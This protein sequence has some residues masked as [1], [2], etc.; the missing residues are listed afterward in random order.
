MRY[1]IWIVLPSVM[2][3]GCVKTSAVTEAADGVRDRVTPAA[4]GIAAGSR[5]LVRAAGQAA[6]D[7][8][9]AARVNGVLEIRR[10]LETQGIKVSAQ[11]GVVTLAGRVSSQAQKRVAG[12]VAG[13][14][15]GVRRVVNR[16]KVG[17]RG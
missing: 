9:L 6:D 5:R 7:A 16:L 10:G 3:M 12:E 1:L 8:A 17:S 13:S 14:T 2:A 4:Q 11:E 15:V